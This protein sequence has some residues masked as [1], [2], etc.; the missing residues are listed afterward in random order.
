ML[1]ANFNS[2]RAIIDGMQPQTTHKGM[3]HVGHT[4]LRLLTSSDPPA[5]AAQNAWITGTCHHTWTNHYNQK[6]LYFHLRTTTE[7]HLAVVSDFHPRQRGPIA[8]RRQELG[9]LEPTVECMASAPAPGVTEPLRGAVL[10]EEAPPGWAGQ[11]SITL[12]MREKQ[13]KNPKGPVAYVTNGPLTM[14]SP[15]AASV[16]MC[17]AKETCLGVR[18]R[19]EQA[20][21][22][23]PNRW[24]KPYVTQWSIS[25]LFL[26]SCGGKSKSW[27]YKGK[28]K[29]RICSQAR[30]APGISVDGI[31]GIN[32]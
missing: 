11:S 26:Q 10:A 16:E 14:Q 15:A 32:P 19:R 17:A 22:V 21:P 29:A 25:M 24:R 5:S 20:A 3:D 12:Q 30:A 1:Y 23:Q 6:C 7:E 13:N 2:N 28:G 18:S 9:C 27:I 4:G 31:P 8:D